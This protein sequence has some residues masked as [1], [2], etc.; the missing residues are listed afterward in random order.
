MEDRALSHSPSV[1]DLF[2]RG[3]DFLESA[4][5]IRD[6]KAVNLTDANGIRQLRTPDF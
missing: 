6:M 1:D 5:A 4:G 2:C 3:R